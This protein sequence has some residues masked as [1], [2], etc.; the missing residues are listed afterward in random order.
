VSDVAWADIRRA[1]LNVHGDRGERFL[2]EL[3]IRRTGGT[4]EDLLPRSQL[5]EAAAESVRTSF[6]RRTAELTATIRH[7]I[8]RCGVA[9]N[10]F[11]L[12]GL[13][14][15]EDE[16]LVEPD[17]FPSLTVLDR[18]M[19]GMV[20]LLP[21]SRLPLE[22]GRGTASDLR[23]MD[24]TV[25]RRQALFSRNAEGRITLEDLG[26]TAGSWIGER[27]TRGPTPMQDRDTVRLCGVRLRFLEAV[28]AH[29]L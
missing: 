5:L 15:R 3:E 22:I 2:R 21:P 11:H 29:T 6:P 8:W 23:L 13:A 25:S 18:D 10:G 17:I 20:F 24:H 1:L 28:A 4:R 12:D 9:G 16:A 14:A 27:I 19:R 26:S 7:A